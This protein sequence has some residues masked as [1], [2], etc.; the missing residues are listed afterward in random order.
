LLVVGHSA[1]TE[2]ATVNANSCS[3]AD[4]SAAVASASGGDTVQIPAGKCL[5]TSTLRLAKGITLAGAGIDQTIIQDEVPRTS[6]TFGIVIAVDTPTGQN[7]RLTGFTITSGAV[8]TIGGAGTIHLSGSSHAFRIDHIKI[9]TTYVYHQISCWGDLWGVIDHSQFI[10]AGLV[11]IFVRHDSW[12]GVGA[13]GDNSWAAPTNLGTAQFI[14]IEDN[15]FKS[16]GGVQDAVDS[17]SGARFVAR[18][19]TTSDMTIGGGHGTDSGQRERSTRVFEIYNNTMAASSTFFEAST[20]RG[21]TG[22]I[23]NNTLKNFNVAVGGINYRDVDSFTPWGTADGSSPYDNN[24]GVVYSSGT[25]T[26]SN[27]VALV[28]TDGTK[29][30]SPNQ[31]VGYS[32]RNTTQ[33]WGSAITSNTATTIT[34]AG[35]AYGVARNWNNGNAYRILSTYPALDQVGNGPGNLL[36]NDVP[37]PAWPNQ[38]AEPVYVWGNKGYAM[39]EAMA[40]GIHVRM[41]RDV[42]NSPKPGYVPYTYPHP[43]LDSQVSAA[44]TNLIVQ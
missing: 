11:A 3:L 40:R 26:G 6:P 25:H 30:W 19:N 1:Q 22:V 10:T 37:T 33:G 27:S 32:L 17:L 41:G 9:N 24:N 44:P 20:L 21:G 38:S 36:S 34:V 12:G 35:S 16:I 8:T 31:W 14:F 29:S 39:A 2:A 5:W 15:T 7:W 28:L 42:I 13:H 23:F 18:Y 4:V 43:L